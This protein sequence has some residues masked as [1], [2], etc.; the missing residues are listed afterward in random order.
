[1]DRMPV[2]RR[3]PGDTLDAMPVCNWA[4]G[5]TLD[6][7]GLRQLL[8]SVI[9]VKVGRL[10]TAEN[11]LGKAGSVGM[12]WRPVHRRTGTHRGKTSVSVRS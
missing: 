8:V 4:L 12:K 10:S 9:Q 3:T 7:G 1:M 5:Y 2:Y 11:E 6:I